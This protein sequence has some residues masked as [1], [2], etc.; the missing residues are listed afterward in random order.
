MALNTMFSTTKPKEQLLVISGLVLV[1]LVV[2]SFLSIIG[3]NILFGIDLLKNSDVGSQLSK[4]IMISALKF[5][6]IFQ[7][8]GVFIIPSILF[9][10]FFKNKNFFPSPKILIGVAFL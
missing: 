6:Q 7:A 4:P 1:C 10:Q 5:M 3:A 8:I 2:F 9:L